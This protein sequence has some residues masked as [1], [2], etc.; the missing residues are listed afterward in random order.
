MLWASRGPMPLTP[1]SFSNSACS[2]SEA[3]PNSSMASSR[4]DL[5]PRVD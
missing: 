3:K 5:V 1:M 4:T 2:S